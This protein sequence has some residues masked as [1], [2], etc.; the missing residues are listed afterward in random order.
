MAETTVNSPIGRIYVEAGAAGVTRM[1]IG[2]A[3]A[4]RAGARNAAGASAEARAHLARAVRQLEEYFAGQRRDFDLRLDLRGTPLQQ[5][6]WQGLLAIPFGRTLTYGELAKQVG[7]PKAARAVG[8]ACGS[9]PVPLVV[10]CHRVIGGDGSLH[11]YGGGLW[12][13]EFLLKH[14]GAWFK[15]RKSKDEIRKSAGPAQRTLKFGVASA[16]AVR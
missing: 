2:R 5:R 16:S 10:P 8:A 12:R 4:G 6:V 1:E 7:V 9:N 13:K 14:E 11:G 3:P 15:E